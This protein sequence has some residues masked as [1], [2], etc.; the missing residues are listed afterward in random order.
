MTATERESNFRSH[1]NFLLLVALFFGLVPSAWADSK[2]NSAAILGLAK[3]RC[4]AC[5]NPDDPTAI[6]GTPRLEGQLAENLVL[7]L[8]NYR[9]GERPHPVMAPIAKV[10]T[11]A[12]ATNLCRYYSQQ[13]PRA[14]RE[15][16]DRDDR[17]KD[18]FLNGNLQTG[19]AACAWCHGLEGEGLAPHFPR[20]ASQV[21][22]YT[23][24]QLNVF[25]KVDDFGNRFAWVM[26]AA[27][28]NLTDEEAMAV[29]EY[30][31]TLP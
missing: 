17:G 18:L 16:S 8:Q 27:I 13:V 14:V 5:H 6:P 7:Q 21:P 3:T 22:D 26:K 4:F 2:E 10:L 15:M 31:S 19:V 24:N 25:A 20:I 28:L 29:A 23:L 11:D 12:Q 1:T 30:L 9:S